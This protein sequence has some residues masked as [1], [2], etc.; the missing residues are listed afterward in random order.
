MNLM[1][2]P[3][4]SA[5]AFRSAR[6]LLLR[7]RG[8]YAAAR[9]EFSWPA[10]EE[11]NWALDWF[12]V[13]A[14]EHPDQTALR[15][16]ADGDAAAQL[17]Y[18]ELA[19]RSS[20]V[21]NWLGELGAR[22]GDHMLLMLGNIAP[23]WEMILAAMKLGVVIIPASTLLGPADLADRIARADVRHVVTEASLAA[24]FDGLG[25]RWTA[26]AVGPG[27]G[28][29]IRRCRSSPTRAGGWPPT[30]ACAGWSSPSCRKRSP[31]RSAGWSC[32]TPNPSASART[33][34]PPRPASAASPS[35][36]RRTS[37]ASRADRDAPGPRSG[38]DVAAGEAGP[39]DRAEDHRV[40][41]ERQQPVQQV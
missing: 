23:L 29:R 16:V 17:S 32:G 24:R 22:R 41:G 20:Q 6:D 30:S 34:P 15:I 28:R 27:P 3:R 21:A 19:A 36:G 25:G 12:D 31:A 13:I 1:T 8:D 33:A 7:H 5:A 39:R 18:G 10:L 37:P 40:D 26:I 2:E 14:A 38:G 9:R 35:S 11:F 4:P